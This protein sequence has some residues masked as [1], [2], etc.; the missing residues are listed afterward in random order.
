MTKKVLYLTPVQGMFDE[1]YNPSSDGLYQA[2]LEI[3]NDR[4]DPNNYFWST[5]FDTQRIQ[6]L[7][8]IL[9]T[10]IKNTSIQNLAILS[11]QNLFIKKL[12]ESRFNICNQ[13]I[14]DKT[15]FRYLETL[16]I[17]MDL[18][19]KYIYY[20]FS[21]S[22]QEAFILN[23]ISS[24]EIIENSLL[25]KKNPYFDFVKNIVY[26]LVSNYKPEIVFLSGKI[27]YF[28][29]TVAR[30]I[31][32][33]FPN[34]HISITNHSSEYFSL[35]KIS[36]YLLKNKNL[37][38]LIDSIILDFFSYTEQELIIALSNDSNISSVNNII[39]SNEQRSIVRTNYKQ[40]NNN[41]LQISY[42]NSRKDNFSLS[43][44]EIINVHLDSLA[45]CH[46]SKC[47]FCGINNKYHS[48]NSEKKISENLALFKKTYNSEKFIWFIDEAFTV[49]ELK[50]IGLFCVEN[51]N[52]INWQARCRLN[53]SLLEDGLPEFLY[54]SGLRELRMGLESASLRITK[55]M[56]KFSEEI[57]LELIESIVETFNKSG[58]SIHFPCIIGF[59]GET[60]K[61]RNETYSFLK[62]L[63]NRYSKFTF[64]INVFTLD[65][66]SEVFKNWYKY[67]INSISFPCNKIDYISN[68]ANFNENN[69]EELNSERNNFMRKQLYDWMPSFS[70]ISPIVFYRL[71]ETIRNTLVWKIKDELDN[72]IIDENSILQFSENCSII[73]DDSIYTI[74]NWDTHNFVKCDNEFLQIVYK[75]KTSAS[76][77]QVCNELEQLNPILYN[78]EDLI[79]IIKKLYNKKFLFH[80]ESKK[81]KSSLHKFTNDLYD[82]IYFNRNFQYRITQDA[83]IQKYINLI[84]KG[85]V[86]EIG[87]GTGKNIEYLI[88]QN[89]EIDALDISSVAISQL[90]KI[91]K[92]N[93]NFHNVSIVDYDLPNDK[94]SLIVCSM[95]LHYLDKTEVKYVITKIKN[96]LQKN[97][98]VYLSVLSESD[99]INTVKDN[100]AIKSAFSR[101]EII[102]YFNEFEIIEA[103]NI[104]T[105][106]PK[107]KN[108]DGYFDVISFFA[109]RR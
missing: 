84:P 61:E 93:C 59:P 20:P 35:N 25:P 2:N 30:L 3:K 16:Q 96:G 70:L 4:L 17:L 52:K 102:S 7:F 18:Y 14:N 101:E 28:N 6:E 41:G 92:N 43:P 15:F 54:N 51:L 82:T 65:V 72:I 58:I 48:V 26:P 106:E 19:S 42:R 23:Q 37:F 94:Y 45:K 53:K 105:K 86:L 8:E 81:T 11:N 38:K 69:L 91:H 88:S 67:D 29:I 32:K 107:R 100:T 90:R 76:V 85:T 63:R 87:V 99:Y 47:T 33:E 39:Y 49:K 108:T 104:L 62:K 77:F 97:G 9:A 78:T 56:N 46:W 57:S 89:F 80:T 109:K 71:S 13:S 95:V 66:S 83:L 50:E 27:N 34:T 40:P 10:D 22:I 73:N 31:K 36:E 44:G 74:Y 60:N 75:F 79:I 5:H 21:L 1:F 103:G 98:C 68:F 12:E 55:L 64:N 24:A